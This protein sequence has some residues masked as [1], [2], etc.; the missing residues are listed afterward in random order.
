MISES[1]GGL[2]KTFRCSFGKE[3]EPH[4][5]PGRAAIHTNVGEGRNFLNSRISSNAPS[6]NLNRNNKDGLKAIYKFSNRLSIYCSVSK[7]TKRGNFEP[8]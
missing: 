2:F 1:P 5:Y 8:F 4:K 6:L 7:Y 3:L